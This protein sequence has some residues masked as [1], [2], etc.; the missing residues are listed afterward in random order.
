VPLERPGDRVVV[1]APDSG[2]LIQR[3]GRRFVRPGDMIFTVG[4]PIS[5]R[6]A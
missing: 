6:L 2:W 3:L 4:M 1:L 5:E